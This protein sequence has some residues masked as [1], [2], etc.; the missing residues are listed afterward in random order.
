MSKTI[1]VSDRI[2]D[3]LRQWAQD[4]AERWP[5]DTAFQRDLAALRDQLDAGLPTAEDVRG[6][7]S[8]IGEGKE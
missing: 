8:G 7:L 1:T 4:E 6:I 3:E 5:P 2:A